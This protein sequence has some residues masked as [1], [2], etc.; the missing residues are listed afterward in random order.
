M[1]KFG[2]MLVLNLTQKGGT[3]YQ[4]TPALQPLSK[5]AT[6]FTRL[7]PHSQKH[8]SKYQTLIKT[9]RLPISPGRRRRRRLR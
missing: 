2:R 4:C 6:P 3:S 9:K 5:I 7:L 8:R 1:N